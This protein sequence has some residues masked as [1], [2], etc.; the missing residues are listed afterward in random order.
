MPPKRRLCILVDAYLDLFTAK[1]AVGLLRHCP[2]EV[3]AVLSAPNAGKNLAEIVGVGAGVP[4]VAS[5]EEALP[6]R[7]DHL[8]LG[9]ALPG[10]QVPP[11]WRA[12]M[13]A[14]LANGMDILNGLHQRLSTD[15]QLAAA[16]A[17]AGRRI[18]DVRTPPPLT[19]VGL[20]KA[21]TTRAKR[22]LTVGTD[23]NLGK[24]VTALEMVHALRGR[25]RQAEFVPT[26]QTGVMIAGWGIAIDAVVSDFVSGAVE[27]M[28]LTKGDAEFILVEGQG[29]ILHPSFSG[30]TLSLIHGAMPD[31]MILCHAPLRRTLRHTDVTFPPLDQWVRLHESLMTPLHPSRVIGVALNTFGM[32]D[33]A[34]RAAVANASKVTGLPATDVIRFG[35]LP[36]VEAVEGM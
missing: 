24:R 9:V 30:V 25:G 27:Q 20:M 12:M 29:S 35:P 8:V 33:A 23:C 21:T 34:A 4:I 16:A 11:A 13:L 15:E 28:V 6:Q 19:E 14:A 1:T 2:D 10:G 3:V 18:I 36:L 7:P 22:I 26:G 32:D 5:I 31:G 17:A